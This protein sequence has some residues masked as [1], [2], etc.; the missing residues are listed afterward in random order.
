MPNAR[1]GHRVRTPLFLQ[2]HASE[3]GAACL[4]AV[5][6]HHGRWVPLRELRKT[7]SVGR[8]GATAADVVEAARHYGLASAGWRKEVGQLQTLPLPA[9]LYWEFNHFVI[10]EGI[11]RDRFHLNDPAIGRRTVSAET[12]DRAF[13]GLVLTFEPGPQFE[14]TDP[15]PGILR[16]LRPWFRGTASGVLLAVASGMMLALLSLATPLVLGVFVDHVFGAGEPWGGMLAG[17]LAACAVLT[18]VLTWCKEACLR[19]L[20]I[21]LSIITSDRCVS[22]LLRLATDFFSHRFAGDLTARM[23]AIDRI[24][25]G[26]SDQLLNVV[27]ELAISVVFL[28]V[29]LTYDPLLA[30]IVVGLAGLNIALMRT[31]TRIRVEENHTLRHEQ[32]M[33]LGIGMSGLNRQELLN[34]TGRDDSFFGR[35]GGYQAREL[36]AR[37]RFAELGHVNTALPGLFSLLGNAVVLLLGAEQVMAGE[38]TLGTMVGFYVVAGMFLAPVGRFV[39]LADRLQILEADLD[40]LDDIIEAPVAPGVA[41]AAT[42]PGRLETVDGRLRLAGRVELRDLTFGYDRKRPPLIDDLSLVIEPGQR[43]AI[44]GASGSGKSTLSHLI[45]GVH[46]PWSGEVLFDGIPI[47]DIPREVLLNTLSVVDQ[48]VVLF[49][50]SIRDNLTLWNSTVPD[51]VLVDAARD[52]CIHDEIVNRPLGYDTLVNEGGRNFSG[53]QRQRLEIARA[54]VSRPSLLILDEA[55]SALDAATEEKIDRALRRRGATCLI[56]AHRLSTIRDSDQIIVLQGGRI[57]QRGTHD[58]LIQDRSGRYFELV[59]AA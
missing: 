56:I 58:R 32:G 43:I 8:D 14:R 35:W 22:H 21:R 16:R 47:G 50:A 5:L 13:T 40:R 37:Q 7:C 36:A 11:G 6:A 49:A 17:A 57:V 23:Q 33:L 52:A 1:R 27:M 19:R 31:I 28:I 46:Q 44:V 20:S 53:G 30:A 18:Y 51:E 38:M 10:L 9:I 39:E 41:H 48:N 55:T 4:G 12:F 42:P 29:M 26:L 2:M 34:A 24:A 59:R 54:L 45:A 25:T 3:C 15:P